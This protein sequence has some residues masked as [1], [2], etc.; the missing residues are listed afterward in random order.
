MNPTIRPITEADVEGFHAALD[1]VC[2][3]GCYLLFEKAPP[4]ESTIEFV[5]DNIKTGNPQ[6]VVIDDDD[7]VIGWCDI[8][9]ETFTKCTHLGHLG[10]GLL[11]G[12][13]GNTIGTQ[14]ILTTIEAAF[15]NGFERIELE[16]FSSNKIAKKLY[17]KVGFQIEGVKRQAVYLNGKYDDKVMMGLL[18][19]E[20]QPE[21][22]LRNHK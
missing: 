7:Q 18:K 11:P 6:F 19:N 9:R 2:R 22:L 17:E 3:E 20:Y 21:T 15:S 12:A 13:R 4:I 5:A 8:R 10:M 1:A 16:V 14:L